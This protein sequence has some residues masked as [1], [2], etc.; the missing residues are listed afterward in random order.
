MRAPLLSLVANLVFSVLF[1]LVT[2]E[3]LA[4]TGPRDLSGWP[5]VGSWVSTWTTAAWKLLFLLSLL[6]V[7]SLGAILRFPNLLDLAEQASRYLRD[8]PGE[9]S[10]MAVLASFALLSLRILVVAFLI[11]SPIML[12]GAWYFIF[13]EV[14]TERLNSFQVLYAFLAYVFYLCYVWLQRRTEN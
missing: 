7:F 3:I 14:D 8:S 10:R 5:I 12:I 1:V 2:L 13:L 9:E 11:I 4:A 6:S